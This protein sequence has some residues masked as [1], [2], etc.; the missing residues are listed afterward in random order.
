MNCA[1]ESGPKLC[2]FVYVCAKLKGARYYSRVIIQAT[3]LS[4]IPFLSIRLY[5]LRVGKTASCPYY[6]G[7]VVQNSNL[8][9]MDSRIA[10]VCGGANVPDNATA[11]GE[12]Q[13]LATLLEVVDCTTLNM[14]HCGIKR[15]F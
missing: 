12:R 2:V 1:L 15:H 5:C 4:T 8:A 10:V 6:N 9:F 7:N 11:I 3:L 14:M 13:L